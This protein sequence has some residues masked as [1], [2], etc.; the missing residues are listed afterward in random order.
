MSVFSS[1]RIR[2]LSKYL[3]YS[4]L[5]I[6]EE[7][8][9]NVHTQGWRL[10]LKG[11]RRFC[12]PYFFSVQWK[13][14]PDA[15]GTTRTERFL[16]PLGTN[17]VQP[18]APLISML[19]SRNWRVEAQARTFNSLMG[20]SARVTAVFLS[21]QEKGSVGIHFCIIHLFML[22]YPFCLGQGVMACLNISTS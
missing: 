10:W 12:S 20:S 18:R 16:C 2:F 8:L 11:A 6:K 13:T 17:R 5:E 15:R 19:I 4:L 9:Y 7:R 3:P 22:S 1:G 14:S 21:F